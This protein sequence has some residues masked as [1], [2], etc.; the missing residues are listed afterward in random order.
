MHVHIL[1]VCGTFMGGVAA[2]AKAAGHRVTGS[3]QAVYPPMSEQLRALGIE[4]TEGYDPTVLEPAPDMVVIGNALSRGNPAV[5]AV[6]DR[7]LAYESGP[8]WLAEHV[9]RDRWVLAVSGTHGK[10]TT[11]SMLAW[12]LEY[13]GLAPGFLI[14][15]VPGNFG[16]TARLGEGPFFVVEADEYDTAFFDKRS[17]FVH[18]RPRT[19][20]LNNLEF[21][22]ADI[23]KDLAAIKWQFHQLMRTVPSTGLVI[24][25]AGEP[26][27]EDMLGAGCWT[28]IQRFGDTDCSGAEWQARGLSPDCSEFEVLQ[29]GQVVTRVSGSMPGR[30]NMSNSLAAM[31]A[32]RHA[33]VELST[34]AL[35]L[36]E[37][38][39][40]R[41]RLELL[42]QPGGIAIYD[43]FAHH[44]TAIFESLAALRARVGEQRILAVLEPRSNTMKLG[45]HKDELA[46]SLRLADRVWAL[47]T[48]GLDWSLES[49][50]A[51]L[52]Q[53]IE[54]SRA[55]EDL[56]DRLVAEARPGD[57]VLIM[58]NGGFGGLHGKLLSRL[59]ELASSRDRQ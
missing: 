44:P 56:A 48:P 3:D 35:A 10:T 51:P 39:G 6:L 1:G 40:V 5:E 8:R 53:R 33:G 45:I 11:S 20:V 43:D 49:A 54:V 28:P 58:S 29:R 12:I 50:L 31:V 19:L 47:Q 24:S 7:G 23:F 55:V 46:E 59:Q 37:F 9:L 25:N 38:R 2:L 13:A 22:H 41:R 27:L 30:H 36:A 4:L 14:G 18:Y 15:G 52:G 42:G 57:H 21:D 34:S 26:E 17:K 32:A 16:V